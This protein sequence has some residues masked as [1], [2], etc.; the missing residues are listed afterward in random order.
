MH[1]KNDAVAIARRF[2]VS[3]IIMKIKP[4]AFARMQSAGNL[5]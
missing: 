2:L 5:K 4:T 3:E 1:E